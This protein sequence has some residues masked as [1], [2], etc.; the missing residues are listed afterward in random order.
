MAVTVFIYL[1]ILF[2]FQGSKSS[3]EL[4]LWQTTILCFL[5]Q[6]PWWSHCSHP[7]IKVSVS[8]IKME[9]LFVNNYKAEAAIASMPIVR[10]L[11]EYSGGKQAPCHAG[12]VW[13]Y[14]LAMQ[15]YH[16]IIWCSRCP[17][18]VSDWIRRIGNFGLFWNCTCSSWLAV[19]T[20]NSTCIHLHHTFKLFSSC[21]Y[22]VMN[23]E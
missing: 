2:N 22:F 7:R 14:L 19:L 9:V 16:G 12:V 4:F 15:S 11:G 18:I 23:N 6:P 17:H 13:P 8:C 1:P 20:I 10:K 5:S 3:Q 21:N